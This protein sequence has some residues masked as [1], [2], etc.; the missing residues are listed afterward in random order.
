MKL[1]FF[2]LR[3]MLRSTSY[4]PPNNKTA[5]DVCWSLERQRDLHSNLVL[6]KAC[7]SSTE[8]N[9]NNS[10][11]VRS[12]YLK[13]NYGISLEDYERII[14]EQNYCC[15]ICKT[16]EAGGK[17]NKRFMIDLSPTGTVRGL[18]CKS[19]KDALILVSD[20]IHTLENMI[21]YLHKEK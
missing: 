20:N 4:R 16:P 9:K 1:D 12:R 10:Y 13:R 8:Y 2:F 5:S 21:Q 14:E 17:F 3:V 11:G 7:Q 19:C 6:S 15:A 18:L